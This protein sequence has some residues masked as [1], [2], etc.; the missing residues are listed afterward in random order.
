MMEKLSY[1]K[2]WKA[3]RYEMI[4]SLQIPNNRKAFLY[5]IVESF[6]IRNEIKQLARRYGRWELKKESHQ[7]D[8]VIAVSHAV[9]G[10]LKG[11][12]FSCV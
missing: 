12:A 9:F 7:I 5:E 1:T 3:F 8:H 6:L 11:V 2:W 10:E 4:E